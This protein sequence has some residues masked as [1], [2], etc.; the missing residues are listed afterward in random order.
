MKLFINYSIYIFLIVLFIYNNYFYNTLHHN[1]YHLRSL[2]MKLN[3]KVLSITYLINPSAGLAN[4]LRGISSSIL[5]SYFHSY[6]YKL[7][8]WNSIIYYFDFPKEWIYFSIDNETIFFSRFNESIFN[9][10]NKSIMIT[11]IYGFSHKL[12]E[13][14]KKSKE[15]IILKEIYNLKSITSYV[16]TSIIYNEIFIPSYIIKRYIRIFNQKKKG[17]KVLGIHI[18]SGKFNNKFNEKYFKNTKNVYNYYLISKKLLKIYNI[19]LIFATS[20]NKN[21]SLFL[22][23]RFK[24]KMINIPFKGEIIHSRFSLYNQYINE[25]A[26]RIVSEFLILSS[27][28]IILGTKYSSFSYESC[29][30]NMNKCIII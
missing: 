25:N 15:L 20:D 16:I 14:Y 5:L 2:L 27:C 11:D 4:S 30:R 8:G 3:N 23:L 12:L 13:K 21:Y 17:E 10:Q 9:I 22:K 19:S 7:K 29:K 1:N 18:R 26:I 6:K 24:D 28:D